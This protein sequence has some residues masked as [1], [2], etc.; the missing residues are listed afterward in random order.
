MWYAANHCVSDHC[1]SEQLGRCT[2]AHGFETGM[3]PQLRSAVDK[4]VQEHKIVLFMKGTPQFP[5][6][7][8]SNTC[9]QVCPCRQSLEL[10]VEVRVP[11]GSLRECILS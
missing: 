2:G 1:V 7:G 4:M 6:C 3:S 9:I 11:A 8:F 10:A 5:Q